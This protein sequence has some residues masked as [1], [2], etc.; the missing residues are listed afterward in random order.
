MQLRK[1]EFFRKLA[2]EKGID[3]PEMSPTTPLSHSQAADSEEVISKNVME[4]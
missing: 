1:D 3:E 2:A 4:K